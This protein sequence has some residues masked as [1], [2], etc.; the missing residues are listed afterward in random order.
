MS[1]E[2]FDVSCR[3]QVPQDVAF[4]LRDE[5]RAAV[6]EFKAAVQKRPRAERAAR[7][8]GRPRAPLRERDPG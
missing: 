4:L 7:W 2:G 5:L 6:E 3:V 1:F 8:C